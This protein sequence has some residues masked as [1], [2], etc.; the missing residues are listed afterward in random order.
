M[1]SN[2]E[3]FEN[4]ISSIEERDYYKYLGDYYGEVKV[5]SR[6]EISEY[7]WFT[8]NQTKELKLGFD[9]EGLIAEL[10]SK[11]LIK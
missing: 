10:Y 9:F 6:N 7:G 4:R 5:N 8:Y 1:A 2:D 3:L 11:N